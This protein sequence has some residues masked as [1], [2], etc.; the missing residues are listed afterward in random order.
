MIGNC[1]AQ[2]NNLSRLSAHLA[3]DATID[4]NAR[5][6][7]GISDHFQQL[8]R[9]RLR[10]AVFAAQNKTCGR[11]NVASDDAPAFQTR[12]AIRLSL[13]TRRGTS[14]LLADDNLTTFFSYC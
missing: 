5:T 10:N 8:A 13:A 14:V 6:K 9:R 12:T 3:T 4:V 7:V 11:R 2:T 1:R